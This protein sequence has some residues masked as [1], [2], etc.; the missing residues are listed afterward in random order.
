VA[1]VIGRTL[2]TV[3]FLIVT[4]PGG[5]PRGLETFRASVQETAT[6]PA[7]RALL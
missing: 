5:T 2:S 1:A 6:V 3:S 4:V 7:S